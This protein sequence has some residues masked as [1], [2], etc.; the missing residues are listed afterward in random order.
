MKREK[1]GLSPVGKVI[2]HSLPPIKKSNLYI[3]EG[4]N[5]L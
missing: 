3:I 5:W 4:G 2:L 1:N